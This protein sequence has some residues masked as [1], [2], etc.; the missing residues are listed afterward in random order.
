M[1]VLV[2]DNLFKNYGAKAALQGVSL[3]VQ[4]GS[5]FGLLGPNGAGKTS[6]V[7]CV[8]SLV[9]YTEGT[10]F[11]AGESAHDPKSR[12]NVAFLPERFNFYPF[13]TVT[14]AIR[15]YA[16]LH[17]ISPATLKE[18]L[19]R[20]LERVKLTGQAKQKIKT[21][22]KGQLQRVGLSNLLLSDA[23]LL[24]LDEPFSG[25]DPIGIRELKDLI[26]EL[27]KE[28]RSVLLNSHILAEVEQIAD[29]IAILNEGKCLASGSIEKLK[30]ESSL[31]E[32]FFKTLKDDAESK[33]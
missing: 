11:I 19:P 7:K 13:E 31:E 18:K 5:V 12:K 9:D 30:Q 6:L 26:L 15:F 14:G 2:V 29:E 23:K 8:L 25:L 28:G 33:A 10:I 1:P 27:K 4:E 32:F 16:S 21:L 22:S 3:R 24:I 20:I 17:G